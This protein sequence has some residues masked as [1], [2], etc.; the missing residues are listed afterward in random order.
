MNTLR[1]NASKKPA[2]A[3]IQPPIRPPKTVGPYVLGEKLGRGG[4]S[5]VY[6]AVHFGTGDIVALKVMRKS[7]TRRATFEWFQNEV[8]IMDALDHVN[9]GGLL[10]EGCDEASGL[11]Y[12]AMPLI[13]GRTLSSVI[14]RAKGLPPGRRIRRQLVSIFLQLCD[15][16]SHA[17]GQKILHRDLKP[18]NVLV[19][20]TGTVTLLDWGISCPIAP[21]QTRRI[22][23]ARRP[24]QE[25]RVAPRFGGTPGYMSPEQIREHPFAQ[26]GRSD[27]WALGALLFE[28]VTLTRMVSGQTAPELLARTLAAD[29]R[30]SQPSPLWGDTGAALMRVARRATSTAP[31]DRFATV[32]A[33][34]DAVRESMSGLAEERQ[35][36]AA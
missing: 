2:Q 29:Y 7:G 35:T 24:A 20:E 15:A 22:L 30:D 26:D 14:R 17:H 36:L 16:V 9:I 23:L 32:G 4:M 13:R 1:T 6:R 5:D 11:L 28:L 27:L 12:L 19:D 10:D 8:A 25:R 3:R 34:A 33:L 31:D 21:E 18:S